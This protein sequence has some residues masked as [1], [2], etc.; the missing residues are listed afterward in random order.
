MS[1]LNVP[2]PIERRDIKQEK[3]TSEQLYELLHKQQSNN[4]IP[5]QMFH[6]N[7]YHLR[8]CNHYLRQR[9]MFASL[10]TSFNNA[11]SYSTLDIGT[12]SLI[13]MRGQDS[14][15]RAFYNACSHMNARLCAKNSEICFADTIRC[16]L[17]H[18]T[19]SS[20]GELLAPRTAVTRTEQQ[21]R[22]FALKQV[23]LINSQGLLFV[24]ATNINPSSECSNAQV[25]DLHGVGGLC[26]SWPKQLDLSKY[27]IVLKQSE[28]VAADW[29][30]WCGR[31]MDLKYDTSYLV[32]KIDPSFSAVTTADQ[33]F[34][35][36]THC[37]PTSAGASLI[38]RCHLV[39]AGSQTDDITTNTD[40]S[41]F[42]DCT[43]RYEQAKQQ[44]LTSQQ[45][46]LETPDD[47]HVMISELSDLIPTLKVELLKDIDKENT[48]RIE[49]ERQW[50]SMNSFDVSKR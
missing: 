4:H 15:I 11:G 30:L 26:V 44:A 39:L 7:E 6:S 9:Y 27:R 29:K 38:T 16:P 20:S 3:S 8:E 28:T 50:A 17:H 25:D 40:I 36:I 32:F 21:R 37:L 45:L 35:V 33:T 22:R 5:V 12:R 19:F 2:Q 18:W 49:Q 48:Y 41:L 23:P 34:V 42:S 43:H 1:T 14:I 46:L 13:I 47:G 24:K 10:S 31:P